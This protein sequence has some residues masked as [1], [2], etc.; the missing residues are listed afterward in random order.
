M[1]R[2]ILGKKENIKRDSYIWNMLGGLVNA[3]QSVFILMV[4]TRTLNIEMA[5]IFT[6]AWAIA[7]L[8]ITIGKYGVRNYQVTDLKEKYSFN[9]YLSHRVIVSFFMIV[10][11]IVYVV[12]TAYANTYNLNK[13]IIILL[14]CYLKLID[15]VEDVFHGMYQQHNRLDIAGKCLTIRLI[16]STISLCL[17]SII[18]KDLMISSVITCILTT[19]IFIYLLRISYSPFELPQIHLNYSQSFNLL[20]DCFPIFAGAFL[21]FYILNAPKY[22][23]DALLSSELQAYY[24]FISMPVFVIGL[25]NNF[26]FQPILTT[27]A[28]SFETKNKKIFNKLVK[29]QIIIIVFLTI[30]VTVGAYIMGI[31]VLSILY[32]S[33][34]TPYKLDL[35][36]LMIGGGILAYVGF[37]TTIITLMRRQN[38]ILC[39]YV[40]MSLLALFVSKYIVRLFE[41]RGASV[42]YLMLISLLAI[43]FSIALIINIKHW[44]E[45]DKFEK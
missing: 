10:V 31:P 13:T 38:I 43:F 6:I 33:N 19:I 1:K 29:K 24:G 2:I 45:D 20:K 27:I 34:L 17:F 7:N 23:I 11:T 41:L 25:L 5:G 35:I 3:F 22:A 39:G 18:V 26:I 16:L 12:Y 15:A 14:M 9:D 44:K 32:N 28:Q 42:L 36:I 37:L 21:S 4:L 40:I 30:I 8:M